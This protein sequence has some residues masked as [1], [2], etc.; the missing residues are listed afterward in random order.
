[1]SIIYE[2]ALRKVT[3]KISLE[4]ID[5]QEGITVEALLDKNW[6]KIWDYRGQKKEIL[7]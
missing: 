2:E 7:C 1:L 5:I 6:E 4:R 3:V